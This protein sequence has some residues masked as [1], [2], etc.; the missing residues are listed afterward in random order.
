MARLV[1]LEPTGPLKIDPATLPADK[2][3]FICQCGLSRK[4][5]YCD[6]AHK[7]TRSEVPA[8]LYIYAR[9]GQ[10]VLETR[11]DPDAGPTPASS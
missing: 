7:I 6:G 11:P 3:L 8:T 5:P 10:S 4:F 2:P 1:R 9:D